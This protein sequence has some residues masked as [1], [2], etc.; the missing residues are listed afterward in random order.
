MAAVATAM[1]VPTGPTGPSLPAPTAPTTPEMA[2]PR[3][4]RLA[5]LAA[6]L[7]R[8]LRSRRSDQTVKQSW[9]LSLSRPPKES[10]QRQIT[11]TDGNDGENNDDDE[12]KRNVRRQM[13]LPRLHPRSALTSLPG[14]PVR[15]RTRPPT[16]TGTPGLS[17]PSVGCASPASVLISPPPESSGSASRPSSGFGFGPVADIFRI[18]RPAGPKRRISAADTNSA[19]VVV[20]DADPVATEENPPSVGAGPVFEPLPDTIP[21][22][23]YAT[24]DPLALARLVGSLLDTVIAHNDAVLHSSLSSSSPTSADT[25]LTRFHSR[26]VPAMSPTS[27][28]LR[29]VE[30]AAVPPAIVLSLIW[31]LDRLSVLSPRFWLSSLTVHRVLVAAVTVAMKGL[32]DAFLTNRMYARIGGVAARELAVLEL[33]LLTKLDWLVVPPPEVLEQYYHRLCQ[34]DP[35]EESPPSPETDAWPPSSLLA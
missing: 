2:P 4:P 11:T 21:P 9:R 10:Q 19:V 23:A 30:H 3:H 24:A 18:A 13:S 6:I 34:T 32:S 15:S 12:H 29:L 22:A 8:P 5:A 27:Y 33:D 7:P 25:L 35:D 26:A 31:L 20:S 1:P 16:P 14:T 28:L 17:A